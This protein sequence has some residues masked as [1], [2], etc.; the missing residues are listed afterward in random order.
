M[1]KRKAAEGMGANCLGLLMSVLLS[2]CVHYVPVGVSTTALGP[3]EK[4][5]GLATGRGESLKEAVENAI[6]NSGADTMINVFVDQE[7]LCYW[8][9]WWQCNPTQKTRV[10]GTLIKYQ[11]AIQKFSNTEPA[12]PLPGKD[13]ERDLLR[14]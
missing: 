13:P 2:G 4:P 5:I 14:R 9:I 10:F 3:R 6:G 11:D 1:K 12:E 8:A 7:W